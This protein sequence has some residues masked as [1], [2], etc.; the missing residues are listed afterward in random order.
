MKRVKKMN[1]ELLV[2]LKYLQLRGLIVNWD[3]YL[4]I[5]KKKNFFLF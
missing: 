3:Y 1:D 5:A 4:E 2:M